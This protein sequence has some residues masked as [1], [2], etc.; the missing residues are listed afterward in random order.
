M[1]NKSWAENESAFTLD[2]ASGPALDAMKRRDLSPEF[3]TTPD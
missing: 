2:V 1:G 3:S